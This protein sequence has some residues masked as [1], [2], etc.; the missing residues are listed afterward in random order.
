MS[1]RE[2]EI[3]EEKTPKDRLKYWWELEDEDD[4][5]PCKHDGRGWDY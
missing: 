2:D 1:R 4:D 5:V 3:Y